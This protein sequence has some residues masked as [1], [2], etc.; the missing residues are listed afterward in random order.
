[1]VFNHWSA[2]DQ[3][4]YVDVCDIQKDIAPLHPHS[5]SSTPGFRRLKGIADIELKAPI[6]NLNV[7][8]VQ[9]LT[10]A[11]QHN[12]IRAF[13]IRWYFIDYPVV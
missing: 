6:Y 3:I 10:C 11:I 1:M 4:N 9:S 8:D 7:L 5:Q 13:D 2:A 12:I